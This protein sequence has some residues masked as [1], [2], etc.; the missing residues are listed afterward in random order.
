MIT[1]AHTLCRLDRVLALWTLFLAGA[2][3]AL[4]ARHGFDDPYITFRYA[5]NLAAGNGFVY[6]PGLR[7]LSTTAPLYALLLTPFAALGLPLPLVSMAIGA[8]S[9]AL[10]ALA[11]YALGRLWASPLVGIVAALIYPTFPLL[12]SALGG[13]AAFGIALVLWGFVAAVAGRWRWVAVLLAAAVVTRADALVAVVC[14][15]LYALVQ[16]IASTPPEPAN[17]R[18]SALGSAFRRMPWGAA[19]LGAIL[20]APWFLFAWAYYGAPTPVTLAAKQRQALLPESRNFAEGLSN[21]WAGMWAHPSY[22]LML[23]LAVIG[24]VYALVRY[25]PW[26]L[27]LGWSGAYGLAYSALGV[28][29]YFW[30]YAPLVPGLAVAVG[31][32]MQAGYDLVASGSKG[33]ARSARTVQATGDRNTVTTDHRTQ[34]TERGFRLSSVVCRPVSA[35]ALTIAALLTTLL[36]AGQIWSLGELRAT[37]D[38]RLEIYRAAGEWLAANTAPDA[39]VGALEVG[40][41]GYYAERP[42][43]DFAGLIQSEVATQFGPQSGYEATARWAIAQYRP[44]YLV[45]PDHTLPLA[46]VVPEASERCHEVAAF[47]A[48]RYPAPLRIYACVW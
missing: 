19:L 45:L 1:S 35:F 46:T 36:L 8:I 15:G 40:I 30:Y 25:R 48:K 6:N 27:V 26:L 43:I 39:S 41:I 18:L 42:M 10:G 44:N 37:P 33:G 5:A 4:F 2:L 22:R 23:I 16:Q 38:D 7:V 17:S 20:C 3:F 21:Y 47:T 31:L 11:L 34:I 28:T 9:H 24:L 13:E 12:V 29:A 14:L 32:G